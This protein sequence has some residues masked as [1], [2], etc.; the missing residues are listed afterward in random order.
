MHGASTLVASVATIA[1]C[2]AAGLLN[3]LLVVGVGLE[4]L[5]ATLGT[6]SI[7][8]AISE[9]ITG[10]QYVGPTRTSF[11]TMA[12]YKPFG[13][14]V[15][16]IYAFAAAVILW[17]ALEHTPVG[18]RICATGA[19]PDTA[20]LAGIAT[21]RYALG[22]FVASGLIAGLGAVL[23]SAKLGTVAP[24]IGAGYLLPVYAAAF[25]SATQVKPGRY[26]VWGTVIAIYLLAT[27]EKGLVLAGGQLW[28]SDMFNGVALIAALSL[29]VV[30]QRRQAARA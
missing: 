5:I 7:F 13:I 21:R 8:F 16:V 22:A 27:G 17:Y 15:L 12:S 9:I 1:V 19:N 25:L 29:A 6:S 14:P 30:F 26:N 3:A 11:Q 24:S 18:R 28:I 23:L 2:G 10:N 4:A 20:R